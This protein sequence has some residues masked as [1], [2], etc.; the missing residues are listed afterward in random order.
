VIDL[1]VRNHALDAARAAVVVAPDATLRDVAR[2]LYLEDV[3]AAVV[4]ESE[5]VLGVIS[6]RDVVRQ[7]ALEDD[8]DQATVARAMT[9]HIATARPD[10]SLLDVVYQMIDANVRHIP[11]VHADGHVAGIVSIRD[12]IRPLLVNH[13]VS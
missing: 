10:D 12:V 4:S 8:P 3:G 1:T 11:V 2:S 6:E 7:L 9:H 5:D 13:F